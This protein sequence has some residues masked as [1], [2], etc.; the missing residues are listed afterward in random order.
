[1][2]KKHPFDLA[3]LETPTDR[4]LREMRDGGLG[5][6]GKSTSLQRTIDAMTRPSI[7]IDP[8]MF[9]RATQAQQNLAKI[10]QPFGGLDG[11]AR[12]LG[13][14]QDAFAK[15]IAGVGGLQRFEQIRALSWG[16]ALANIQ[17]PDLA[18]LYGT[19]P[20]LFGEAQ[21]LRQSALSAQIGDAL[22]KIVGF[23]TPIPTSIS[24]L[25]EDTSAK[26]SVFAGIEATSAF[27]SKAFQQAYAGLLGSWHTAPGLPD[28]FWRDL[29]T[30]ERFYREASVDPGII[31]APPAATVEVMV[32]AGLAAGEPSETGTVALFAFGNLSVSI[33]SSSPEIDAHS[34]VVAFER[35]LRTYIAQKLETIA[36][37]TWFKHRAPGGIHGKAKKTRAASLAVGERSTSLIDYTDFGELKEIVLRNDNWTEVFEGIF[38]N[39]GWFE[40]DVQTLLALR[41]PSSHSRIVDSTQILE[42][43]LVMRRLD[44]QM[45]DDGAWMTIANSDD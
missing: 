19:A 26:M 38:I 1:M 25:L 33:R 24:K 7:G 11:F 2:P 40:R 16:P 15:A 39:R 29:E 8:K 13:K 14:N 22:S 45:S 35:R 42:A 23:R 44:E 36:G 30:R 32:E 37:P 5:K 34:A 10:A 43:L 4:L 6:L 20:Q 28:I 21:K 41:R 12:H 18:R 3:A 17:I 31:V 9:E 27:N